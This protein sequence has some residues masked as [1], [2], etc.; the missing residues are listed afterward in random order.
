MQTLLP[1][2]RAIFLLAAALLIPPAA[3]AVAADSDSAKPAANAAAPEIAATPP[4]APN[5]RQRV[6]PGTQKQPDAKPDAKPAP[7]QPVPVGPQRVIVQPQPLRVTPPPPPAPDESP[8]AKAR[9]KEISDWSLERSHIEARLALDD[10]RRRAAS[11][12]RNAEIFAEQGEEKSRIDA[13]L[14]LE[15][16]RD[17][18]KLIKYTQR[19]RDLELESKR[20]QIETNNVL[21]RYGQQLATFQKK[22][23]TERFAFDAKAKLLKEPLVN[24]TLFISD[25]RVTLNGP[26]TARMAERVIS[27]LNFFNNQNS[28]FPIFLV[29]DNSPGGSVSAGFQILKAMESSKAPVYVVV[30]GFAASMAAVITTLAERSYSYNNTIILHHQMSTHFM[31]NMSNLRDQLKAAEQWYARLAT[32]VAKKMG[33]TLEEFTKQMYKNNSD[34]DWEEFGDKAKKIKWVDNVVDRIVETSILELRDEAPPVQIVLVRSQNGETTPTATVPA[35]SVTTL[36]DQNG[37]EAR[38]DAKGQ[39]FVQLPTLEN[40]FDCWWIYDKRNFYRAR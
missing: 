31:G 17:N 35:S 25:R 32:P 6:R 26:V 5:G 28:E 29:I 20:L 10:A 2:P 23:E 19:L 37:C 15:S 9:R 16:S 8:E 30:K 39:A 12:K 4:G 3:I 33:I 13:S 7:G 40:P 34:G 22:R 36:V 1:R 11:A 24:G 27:R 38:T 14:A 18:A 21:T